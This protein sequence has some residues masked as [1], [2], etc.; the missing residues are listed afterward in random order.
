VHDLIYFSIF[1]YKI[2]K[3]TLPFF[4]KGGKKTIKFSNK[5]LTLN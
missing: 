3:F 4:G 2:G 5:H 1:L